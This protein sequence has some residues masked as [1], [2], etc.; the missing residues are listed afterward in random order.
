MKGCI[1]CFSLGSNM[2]DRVLHLERAA[3]LLRERTGTLVS[4]SGMYESPSWGYD[5]DTPFINCCLAIRTGLDP[6]DLM[7][8]A[9]GIE[10]EM[11]RTRT[12]SGYSDRV[13]DVD[14]LLCGELVMD[15][16]RLVVPHPRMS[17]RRFVLL[18][19]AEI[20]PDLRHPVSGLT[21]AQLLEQCPDQ[22]PVKPV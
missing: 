17:L 22:S 15:H 21:I 6:L 9:R 4:L 14:L 8:T 2:G 20:L 12:E 3:E 7:G 18:P 19:L 11:G 1:A 16:P 13:I 5:S 10:Q